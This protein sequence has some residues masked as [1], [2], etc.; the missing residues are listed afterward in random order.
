M[1]YIHNVYIYIYI[2]IYVC[3]YVHIYIRMTMYACI[4]ACTYVYIHVGMYVCMYVCVCMYSCAC[5]HIHA[6]ILKNT[7]LL[8]LHTPRH[9]YI[10]IYTLAPPPKIHR[11]CVWTPPP[12]R[13]QISNF[14]DFQPPGSRFLEIWNLEDGNV[15][16]WRWKS[17]NLEP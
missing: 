2:Y 10:Y 13:F 9:I 5:T 7:L 3:V 1:H 8:Y 16:A 4:Y 17:G 14:P 12:T 11:C 15:E 6:Y